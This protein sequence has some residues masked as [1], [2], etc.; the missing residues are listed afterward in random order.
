VREEGWKQL[1]TVKATQSNYATDYLPDYAELSEEF[2]NTY[3]LAERGRSVPEGK[4]K[5]K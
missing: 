2:I 1:R 4:R 3:Q 5:V